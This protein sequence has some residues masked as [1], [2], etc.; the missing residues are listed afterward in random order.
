[1]ACVVARAQVSGIS[2]FKQKKIAAN[3]NITVDSFSIVPKSFFIKNVDTSF[4]TIDCIN[5]KISWKKK[6]TADSVTI[7][8]RVFPNSF[9][10]TYK[11][12]NYDSI[13]NNFTVNVKSYFN[14]LK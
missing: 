14:D 10:K 7:Y 13:K 9:G 6:T 1:M 12:F 11:R 3:K 2:N 8:Y 4:Y 5:A